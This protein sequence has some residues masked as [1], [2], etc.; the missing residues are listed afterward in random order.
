MR[1]LI[2]ETLFYVSNLEHKDT[3]RAIL[4]VTQHEY[5]TNAHTT[6]SCSK[7]ACQYQRTKPSVQKEKTTNAS[8]EHTVFI[9]S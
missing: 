4:Q 7:I 9:P 5:Y 1:D 6:H 8:L 2:L 3:T